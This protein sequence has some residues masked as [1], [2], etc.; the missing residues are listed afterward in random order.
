MTALKLGGHEANP[1]MKG[2]VNNPGVLIGL[3]AAV[4]ATSMLAAEKMWRHHNRVGAIVV[5]AIS[6]GMMTAVA[7]HN[8]G[9][10][11]SLR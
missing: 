10:V 4:T 9:V 7:M 6:N 3:K 1:L 8:A 11:N 5:M 2:A